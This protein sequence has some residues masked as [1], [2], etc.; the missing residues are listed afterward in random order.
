MSCA[1]DPYVGRQFTFEDH[2]SIK[3]IETNLRDFGYP[4]YWVIYEIK[5]AK[6]G[7]PKRLQMS[8]KEFIGSFG[9]LFFDNLKT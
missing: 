6:D 7:I 2:R 4:E 5:F 9:H 1:F 3:I 8:E